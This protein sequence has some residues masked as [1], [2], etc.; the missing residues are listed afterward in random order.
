RRREPRPGALSRPGP[1]GP[2]PARGQAAR[3][4]RRPALLRGRA[5]GAAG[6]G[7]RPVRAAAPVSDDRAG[8]ERSGVAP[9][10]EPAWADRAAAEAG[11]LTMRAPLLAGDT[12]GA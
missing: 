11:P 8:H 7:R 9:A 1:A 12:L 5:A 4:R 10:R 3:V 6:G 2:D